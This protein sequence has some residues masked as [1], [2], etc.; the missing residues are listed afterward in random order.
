MKTFRKAT[1]EEDARIV[2]L[3]QE[4][5]EYCHKKEILWNDFVS[6]ILFMGT[7]FIA[8]QDKDDK[9]NYPPLK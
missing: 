8:R 2:S 3:A 5:T 9:V 7:T 4:L 6:T 1:K